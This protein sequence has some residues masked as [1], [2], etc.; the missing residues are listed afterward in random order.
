MV[1]LKVLPALVAAASLVFAVVLAPAANAQ[2]GPAVAQSYARSDNTPHCSQQLGAN[3]AAPG[4]LKCFAT[5]AAAIS[6]ATGDPLYAQMTDAQALSSLRANTS[7]NKTSG[8]TAST[9]A[10]PGGSGAVLLSTDYDGYTSSG[11]SLWWYGDLACGTSGRYYTVNLGANWND[12]ISSNY[13]WGASNCNHVVY[14]VNNWQ[15]GAFK[16]CGLATGV[17]GC[18]NFGSVLN[19]KA[20]SIKWSA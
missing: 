11:S 13:V 8:P 2:G 10:T 7:K 19:N 16:D 4:P 6:I 5:K 15:S 9:N 17:Q 14:Y 1:R 18:S 3:G 20:T 12:R